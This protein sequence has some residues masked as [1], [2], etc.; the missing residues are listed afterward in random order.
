MPPTREEFTPGTRVP[1]QQRPPGGT[2]PPP[3]GT[4]PPAQPPPGTKPPAGKPRIT[5]DVAN[6]A[7]NPSVDP[8]PPQFANMVKNGMTEAQARQKWARSLQVRGKV[9]PNIPGNN[10]PPVKP[11]PG[12][13]TNQPPPGTQP[14]VN[15]PPSPFVPAPPP[16]TPVGS[17]PSPGGGYGP[18][19]G[20]PPG[21][22]S[23][24][25]PIYQG[26]PGSDYR[27]PLL[28][29]MSLF[30]LMNVNRDKQIAEGL[31][32]AGGGGNRF[33]TYAANT[34][35]QIGA[36]TGMQ[37][38]AMIQKALLDFANGQQD[39]SLAAGGMGMQLGS[40]MDQM[41]QDRVRL[42]AELGQYEQGRQ[43]RFSNLAYED[44]E[45]NKLGWLPL[46]LGSAQGQ[47]GP[48]PGP[49]YQTQTPGDPG[50]AP[51][52]ELFKGLFS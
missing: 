21:Y 29:L 33:G 28:P 19:G 11:P 15:P 17:T 7:P 24:G 4:A 34:A 38:N 10:K 48:T 18:L 8:L 6:R 32:Q 41:A 23:A 2:T 16:G 50:L 13:P 14:P 27:D 5:K 30:P 20:A 9:G 36:E 37:Q 52:L 51:L 12:T 49:I 39:R 1:R 43:D 42:P 3:A 46:L 47:H 40:L 35:A 45:R 44:F 22:P 31:A 25:S 26:P